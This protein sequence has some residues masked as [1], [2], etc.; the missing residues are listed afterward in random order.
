MMLS[1][2]LLITLLLVLHLAHRAF[3]TNLFGLTVQ[4]SEGVYRRAFPQAAW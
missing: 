4:K 2:L 3:V 1:A